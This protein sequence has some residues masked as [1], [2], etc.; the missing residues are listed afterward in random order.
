MQIHCIYP[1]ST[2]SPS[3][4]KE[5]R[6]DAE[7]MTPSREVKFGTDTI[8]SGLL[9]ACKQSRQ[10]AL[11]IHNGCIESGDRKIRFDKENDVIF[12]HTVSDCCERGLP[13][14][15]SRPETIPDHGKIFADVQHLAMCAHALNQTRNDNLHS[16]N[17]TIHIRNA[18]PS[19]VSEFRSLQRFYVVLNNWKV[20]QQL[21]ITGDIML[22]RPEE[23]YAPCIPTVGY[24]YNFKEFLDSR[25]ED[26][27]S[28]LSKYKAVNGL[29][30]WKVPNVQ[31]VGINKVVSLGG[32]KWIRTLDWHGIWP[33]E[34]A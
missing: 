6:C 23:V 17:G 29:D 13:G 27:A 12:L 18:R 31:F 28:A 15:R 21:N 16:S 14:I 2:R 5:E 7:A 32:N 1:A 9:R 26:I 10:V 25:S 22:Y 20:M 33:K 11:K 30:D 8:S 19:L 4:S 34:S 3:L 24:F